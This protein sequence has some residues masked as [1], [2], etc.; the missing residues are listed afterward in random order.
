MERSNPTMP[1]R[2]LAKE[3]K[4]LREA[5]GLTQLEVGR[6]HVGCPSTTISKIETGERNVP[7]PHLRLML[8]CYNVQPAHAAAL[9]VL[10]KQAREPGWWRT[11]AFTVPKWF[12]EYLGL[13]TAATAADTYESE[14]VPGLLQTPRY[15]EAILVS[16]AGSSNNSEGAA[17]VRTTRQQ[18]PT[19]DNPLTVRTILNEAVLWRPIGSAE[20][21]RE[22]LA[23]L[24]VAAESNPNVTLRVLP[25]SAGAHPGMTGPFTILRFPEEA[26]DVV[27]I[28]LR[29]DAVYRDR[30]G[31]LQQY[32]E[33]FERLSSLALSEFD[34]ISLLADMERRYIVGVAQE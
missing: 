8:Q 25:F 2:Q 7:E 17:A 11:R 21:L 19:S 34:T 10:A 13:E 9:V 26:M 1:A 33:V 22:Q 28:E 23:A 3:L 29:G 18:R 16:T 27:F 12:D 4:R 24:R 31:D 6:D 14:Y 15:I 20:V 32:T 5:S 30:A